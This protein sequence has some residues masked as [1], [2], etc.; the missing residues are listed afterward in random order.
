MGASAARSTTSASQVKHDL[1]ARLGAANQQGAVGRSFEWLWLVA[2]GAGNQSALAAMTDPRPARPPDRNIAGLGEFEQAL[3]RRIPVDNEAA[4]SERDQRSYAGRSSRQ[5]RRPTRCVHHT[6]CAGWSRPEDLC[7]HPLRADA[8]GSQ[9]AGQV[10]QER[11]WAAQIE[12]R[13]ARYADLLEYRH[14]EMSRSEERRVGKECRSRWSP[15]H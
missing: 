9:P 12:V 6:G 10:S 2:D 5:V 7:V 11:G 13:L 3:Q 8:S 15:Y 14:A 1:I 4:A